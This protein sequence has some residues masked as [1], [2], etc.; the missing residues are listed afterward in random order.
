MSDRVPLNEVV[1]KTPET[2]PI[3]VK[4]PPELMGN[5]SNIEYNRVAD[6]LG[7]DYETRQDPRMAEKIDFMFKWGQTESGSEDRL[8]S[9]VAIQNLI[10]GL[11]YTE[12]GPEMIK[13]VYKWMRLD[14]TR[15]RVETEMTLI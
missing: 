1:D 11:G 12:K 9:L 14:S 4:T 15:K 2:T 7:I 6:F 10:K 8:K 3:D 5:E 13:K